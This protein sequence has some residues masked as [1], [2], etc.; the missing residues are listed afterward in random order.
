MH[1][2]LDFIPIIAF[3]VAY[4]LQGIYTATAL[5]MG[6]SFLHLAWSRYKTG[7]FESTP[8]YTFLTI[9]V[10]GSATLFF[11]NS[12]FIKWKPTLVYWIMGLVFLITPWLKKDTL[13]QKMFKNAV[14][15]PAARWQT[16]N[17]VWVVFFVLMGNLNLYVAY[18]YDTDTWVNFKLFGTLLITL[19]FIVA[20]S[21]FMAK[22][23]AQPKKDTPNDALRNDRSH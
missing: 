8:L 15:L 23:M 12:V 22:Y 19:L 6:L 17:L 2:L 3:F 5:A 4:K 21:I 13:V 14:T 1:F 18:S 7:R 9:A 11:Q 20:Q 16:L 10:L